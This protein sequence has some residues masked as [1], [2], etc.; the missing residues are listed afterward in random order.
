MFYVS[1]KYDN[2]IVIISQKNFFPHPNINEFT[3]ALIYIL[4]RIKLFYPNNLKNIIFTSI[5][6]IQMNILVLK[7]LR[8]RV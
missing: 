2:K 6:S 5:K 8:R 3:C 4:I 1:Q 7:I